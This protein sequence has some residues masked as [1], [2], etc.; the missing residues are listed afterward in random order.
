MIDNKLDESLE[1]DTI[2]H[3]NT[4]KNPAQDYFSKIHTPRL[5][6]G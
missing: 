1:T 2:S 5:W 4:Q 3:L 6:E